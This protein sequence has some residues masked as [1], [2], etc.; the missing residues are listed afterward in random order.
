MFSKILSRIGISLMF[1][2]QSCYSY[3]AVAV[4]ELQVGKQYKVKIA[5]GREITNKCIGISSD[6]VAFKARNFRLN[7]LKSDIQQVE[8][9]RNSPFTY[10]AAAAIPAAVIVT[11]ITNKKE[12]FFSS[13]DPNN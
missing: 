3:N 4:N 1:L 5:D 13:T 8:R 12:S 9:K 10:I 11:I 7:I 2:L 6:S